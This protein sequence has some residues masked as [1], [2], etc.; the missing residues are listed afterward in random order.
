MKTE[1]TKTV[2]NDLQVIGKK[3]DFIINNDENNELTE[4]AGASFR[5]WLLTPQNQKKYIN[6]YGIVGGDWQI[7][8]ADVVEMV[9]VAKTYDNLSGGVVNVIYLKFE[10]KL[11]NRIVYLDNTILENGNILLPIDDNIQSIPFSF[12]Y[13][14]ARKNGTKKQPTTATDTKTSTKTP[15]TATKTVKKAV[16]E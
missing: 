1:N 4:K 6:K 12:K 3:I 9:H 5:E 15:K 16:A 10:N 13:K 11:L 2:T 7:D 14:T 8:I